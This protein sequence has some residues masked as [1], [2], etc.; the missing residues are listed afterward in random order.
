M[1]TFARKFHFA[2]SEP[3][4]EPE[5]ELELRW[6][7][8]G[9]TIL[10]K[11][12]RGERQQQLLD[13]KKVGAGQKQRDGGYIAGKM[14]LKEVRIEAL[15]ERGTARQCESVSRSPYNLYLKHIILGLRQKR[16]P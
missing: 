1:I 7:E 15:K 3:E 8:G 2:S 11:S 14:E 16:K 6:E 13:R 12:K 4:L 5:L 9:T 10:D